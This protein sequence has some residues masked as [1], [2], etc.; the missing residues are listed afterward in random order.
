MT[1]AFDEDLLAPM[2]A[3]W[4][5]VRRGA[6]ARFGRGGL[7]AGRR[8]ARPH[9]GGRGGGRGRR[10]RVH[11]EDRQ[12]RLHPGDLDRHG[13]HNGDLEKTRTTAR[14]GSATKTGCSNQQRSTRTTRSRT[15]SRRRVNTHTS[16]RS[17]PTWPVKSSSNPLG[18]P[19]EFVPPSLEGGALLHWVVVVCR[20]NSRVR[21]IATRRHRSLPIRRLY[22]CFSNRCHNKS[23]E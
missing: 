13:R 10:K 20:R 14:T 15:P 4:Q 22:A 23:V 1:V 2:L 19:G 8:F 12:L 17:I 9:C 5:V 21:R 7:A 3:G 18:R 11:R 16:A 6:S